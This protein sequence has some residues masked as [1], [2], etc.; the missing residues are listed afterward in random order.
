MEHVLNCIFALAAL[1][2][3]LDYFG[4]KPNKPLWGIP[5]PPTRNWKLAVMLILVVASLG[6]N[7][8]SFYRSTRPKIV[9]KVI[10][11]PVDRIVEKIVQPQCPKV[12]TVKPRAQKKDKSAT[13]SVPLASSP[14]PP[15][16]QDCGGGNCAQSNGQTG[17]ITA[18][19]ITNLEPITWYDWNGSAHRRQGNTFSAVAGQE[20]GNFGQM[21]A[22]EKKSDWQGLRELAEKSASNNASWPTPLLELSIADYHMCKKEEAV[23]KMRAF[24]SQATLAGQFSKS[25]D[26]PLKLAQD[27]ITAMLAGKWPSNCSGDA[28]TPQ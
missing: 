2:A 4:V 18:G 9:E 24:I 26:Q 19:Q 10:E 20:F 1:L 13:G 27:N 14:Q 21:L 17:G 25:Y 11:K 15:M 8:Y 12:E 16:T 7:G 23:S 28:S 5:M 3:I 22:L 6:M